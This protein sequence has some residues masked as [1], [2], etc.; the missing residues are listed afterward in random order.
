LL[1]E[2]GNGFGAVI[3]GSPRGRRFAGFDCER[4]LRRIRVLALFHPR[5]RPRLL[6]LPGAVS[7]DG[8]RK[9]RRELPYADVCWKLDRELALSAKSG[10]TRSPLNLRIAAVR[11]PVA[12]VPV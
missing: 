1:T 10:H 11:G 9:D 2:Q 5:R 3:H 7:R 8:A 6:G 4:F 12:L